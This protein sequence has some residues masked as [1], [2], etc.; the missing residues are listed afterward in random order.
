MVKGHQTDIFH[1][2]LFV[3][4]FVL[5]GQSNIAMLGSRHTQSSTIS[6]VTQWTHIN[7]AAVIVAKYLANNSW[8]IL[9]HILIPFT[10]THKLT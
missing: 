5:T 7:R 9:D 8:K 10:H 6:H 4:S 2:G 3:L 1:M